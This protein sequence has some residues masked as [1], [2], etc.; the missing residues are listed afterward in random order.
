MHCSVFK[1]VSKLERKR[2]RQYKAIK[3]HN[4]KG[5]SIKKFNP[6][7]EISILFVEIIFKLKIKALIVIAVNLIGIIKLVRNKI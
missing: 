4:R 5:S 6:A 3:K 7:F 1:K 2:I